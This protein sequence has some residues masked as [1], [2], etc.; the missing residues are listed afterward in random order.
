MGRIWRGTCGH[1]R[2][3]EQGSHTSPNTCPAIS[4]FQGR[5]GGVKGHRGR[6]QHGLRLRLQQPVCLPSRVTGSHGT[7]NPCKNPNWWDLLSL[8]KVSANTILSKATTPPHPLL[9][10]GEREACYRF[11]SFLFQC[12]LCAMRADR[13]CPFVGWHREKAEHTTVMKDEH[14]SPQIP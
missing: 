5:S 6:P 12:H 7:D 13:A 10:V 11:F 14:R 2:I 1:S 4:R 9:T 8:S 3:W